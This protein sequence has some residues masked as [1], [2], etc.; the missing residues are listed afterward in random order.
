MGP[1]GRVRVGLLGESRRLKKALM[2]AEMQRVVAIR[3]QI[4]MASRDGDCEMLKKGSDYG[5]IESPH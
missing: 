2:R 3:Y 5:D 1:G 4:S